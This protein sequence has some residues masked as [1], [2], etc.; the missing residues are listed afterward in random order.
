MKK[1]SRRIT[2]HKLD[3]VFSK[4][5]RTMANFKC[6]YYGETKDR[7]ELHHGI[8]HRRYLNTWF[9]P[10]NCVV[11]CSAC[12]WL[13]SDFPRINND[14]FVKRIGSERVEQIEIMARSGKKVS[15]ETLEEL[16]E[17]YSKGLKSLEK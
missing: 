8:A 1:P 2:T 4:Y 13:F 6:Q 16:Y 11:L 7:T 12:H 3:I 15:L 5:V 10:D 14:F 9:E 17:K